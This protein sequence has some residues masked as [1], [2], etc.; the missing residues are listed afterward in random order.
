MTY[1]TSVLLGKNVDGDSLGLLYFVHF[2]IYFLKNLEKKS[3]FHT[4]YQF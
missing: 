2:F 3:N 4:I 1:F